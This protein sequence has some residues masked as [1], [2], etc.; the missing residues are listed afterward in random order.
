MTTDFKQV[1][2]WGACDCTEEWSV[3]MQDHAIHSFFPL[4]HA[5][6]RSASI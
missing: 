6:H 3:P 1:L 5:G 2:S 4:E